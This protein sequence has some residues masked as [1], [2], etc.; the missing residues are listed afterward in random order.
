MVKHHTWKLTETRP[1]KNPADIRRVFAC[2]H[3]KSDE[4]VRLFTCSHEKAVKDD[5]LFTYMRFLL[6]NCTYLQ[7]RRRGGN[8]RLKLKTMAFATRPSGP[9]PCSLA[10]ALVRKRRP[11][12]R[13][14]DGV[15]HD[16]V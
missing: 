14:W 11:R 4:I 12:A 16:W 9:T 8:D 5:R 6:T 7:S 2:S 3:K 15:K 10:L 1:C 13:A